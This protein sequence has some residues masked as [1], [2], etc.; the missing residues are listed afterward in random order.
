MDNMGKKGK[1]EIPEFAFEPVAECDVVLVRAAHTCS[2]HRRTTCK[3]FLASL[4][5]THEGAWERSRK[6]RESIPLPKF[7]K[8]VPRN[9]ESLKWNRV[10]RRRKRGGNGE[11]PRVA[12]SG[13]RR[14][15]AWAKRA[16]CVNAQARSSDRFAASDEDSRV[17]VSAH[18]LRI[19]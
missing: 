17:L 6:E 5:N 9:G 15:A 7:Q 2:I 1:T 13:G 11:C 14:T 8:G 4:P 3:Y 10:K 18:C 19:G 16:V 12:T